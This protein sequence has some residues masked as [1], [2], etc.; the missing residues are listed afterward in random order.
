MAGGLPA[1]RSDGRGDAKALAITPTDLNAAGPHHAA[2]RTSL[3]NA[4]AARPRRT[5]AAARMEKAT[6]DGDRVAR[7]RPP[8]VAGGH[9]HPGEPTG[10]RPIVPRTVAI[11][12]R[13][14]CA[15]RSHGEPPRA[16]WRHHLSRLQPLKRSAVRRHRGM[17]PVHQQD[18][19][20]VLPCPAA[21]RRASHRRGLPAD[22]IQACHSR[23]RPLQ[24]R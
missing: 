3:R 4:R 14:G 15:V 19:V 16:S 2:A 18:D 8:C 6:A 23:G 21:L 22:S 7:L 13:H 11:N 20:T 17:A 1:F 10:T 5:A 24:V 12:K 9:T